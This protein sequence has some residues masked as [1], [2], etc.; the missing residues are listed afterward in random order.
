MLIRL[1]HSDEVAQLDYLYKEETMDRYT[2]EMPPDHI[3]LAAQYRKK[4][5]KKWDD[6]ANESDENRRELEEHRQH[7]KCHI[8]GCGNSSIGPEVMYGIRGGP[9]I[10][11]IMRCLKC[12]EWTCKE[13]LVAFQRP[14]EF[15]RGE[16]NIFVS[17]CIDCLPFN[18]NQ[19]QWTD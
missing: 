9:D 17:V 15:S 13:H 16:T 18:K 11:G 10:N 3:Y 8:R 4:L 5:K 7:Y 14:P 6:W 19:I 2:D 12:N 1:V